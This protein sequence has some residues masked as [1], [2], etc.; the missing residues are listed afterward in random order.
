MS[1][2]ARHVLQEALLWG[3]VA[4]GGFALIY[5]FD[6]LKAA[7]PAGAPLSRRPSG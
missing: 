7:S 5:F 6:D 1:L 2:A 3:A 4:L